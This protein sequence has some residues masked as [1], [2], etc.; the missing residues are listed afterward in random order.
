MIRSLVGIGPRRSESRQRGMPGLSRGSRGYHG[1][2]GN[3]FPEGE[4][5]NSDGPTYGTGG[6]V[7][8]GID[9]HSGSMFFTKDGE[10][11]GKYS[12]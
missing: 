4:V 10:H 6:V 12:D 3:T 2:D 5:E 9:L 7:G 11:L 8:C 1:D